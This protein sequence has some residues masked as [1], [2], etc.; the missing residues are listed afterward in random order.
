MVLC[1]GHAVSDDPIDLKDIDTRDQI[2]I[3]LKNICGFL[4]KQI[5]KV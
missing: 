2:Q 3:L 1:N 5:E 4:K